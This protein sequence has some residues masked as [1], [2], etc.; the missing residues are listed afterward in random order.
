MNIEHLPTAIIKRRIDEI[1]E[2]IKS[3][4]ADSSLGTAEREDLLAD[5]RADLHRYRGE[6]EFRTC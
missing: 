4:R 5:L 2:D 1:R 6:L 3:A